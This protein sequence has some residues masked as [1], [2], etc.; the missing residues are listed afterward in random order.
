MWD[1]SD[2]SLVWSDAGNRFV[3][4]AQPTATVAL[5]PDARYLLWTGGDDER[6]EQYVEVVDL[7]AGNSVGIRHYAP[8]WNWAFAPDGSAVV[9]SSWQS[10]VHVISTEDWGLQTLRR[11]QGSSL[12]D[13]A[14]SADGSVAVTVG[15]D[16]TIRFW[17]WREGI[18]LLEIQSPAT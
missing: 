1:L 4:A 10:N 14:F 2:G 9:G 15:L 16:N 3:P 8:A 12:R 17:D 7:A 6:R 11:G 13:L 5:S 18:V